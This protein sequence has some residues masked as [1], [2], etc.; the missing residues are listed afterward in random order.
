MHLNEMNALKTDKNCQVS[1]VESK[2]GT[3]R[4]RDLIVLLK[5]FKEKKFTGYVK[6]NYAWGQIRSIETF[7]EILK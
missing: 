5:T 1:M 4:L 3:N 2:P 7:E 6:V